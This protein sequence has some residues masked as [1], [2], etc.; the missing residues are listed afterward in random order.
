MEISLEEASEEFTAVADGVCGNR[1]AVTW[2]SCGHTW[3]RSTMII[4]IEDDPAFLAHA[5]DGGTVSFLKHTPGE[6]YSVGFWTC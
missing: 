4:K 5:S 2:V 1:A 6:N 3:L